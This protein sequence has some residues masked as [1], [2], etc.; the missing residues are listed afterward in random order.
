MAEGTKAYIEDQDGNKILPATDWSIVQNKPTN[1]ARTDQLPSLSPWQRDGIVYKNGAYD[2]DH[3]HNGYNCAYRV[4]D[5]GSFKLVEVRLVFGVNQDI[6]NDT[7]VIDLPRSIQPDGDEE[8]NQATGIRGVFIRL[9]PN[10]GVD[11]YC[12]KMGDG[13]KYTA[14]GMLSLHTT[15][16]TTI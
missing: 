7:E 5:M 11:V 12:Q 10:M 3:V 6:V 8:I 2:W 1:L 16:F 9:R 15:Y 4:A 13:D 14:N